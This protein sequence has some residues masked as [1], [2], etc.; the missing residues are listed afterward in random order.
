MR[1]WLQ[2][3]NLTL[4]IRLRFLN[5][6]R[7]PSTMIKRNWWTSK[8]WRLRTQLLNWRRSRA[9]KMKYTWG[10]WIPSIQRTTITNQQD[11]P[12]TWYHRIILSRV[13][14]ARRGEYWLRMCRETTSAAKVLTQS[15][16]A[17]AKSTKMLNSRASVTLSIRIKHQVWQSHQS[18]QKHKIKIQVIRTTSVDRLISRVIQLC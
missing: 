6:S 5:Q 11:S 10:H 3:P 4:N 2:Y 12:L 15:V 9:F 13:D 14:K 1:I 17:W 7:R 8:A 16:R 18:Y